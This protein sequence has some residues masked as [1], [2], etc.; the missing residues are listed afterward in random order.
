MV[1]ARVPSRGWRA[2]LG[3]AGAVRGDFLQRGLGQVV[4]D[5]PAV[6]YLLG[7]GQDATDGLGVRAGAVAAH[8]LDTGM[9]PQ[10]GLESVGAAVG[11]D[12]DPPPG[13]DI[14][15]HGGVL[16]PPAQGELVHPE[17]PGYPPGG[18]RQSQQRAQGGVPREGHVQRR[19]QAGARATR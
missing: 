1:V 13:L 10:P 7:V 2:G 8:H 6:P 3:L 4:P 12:V 5:V 17:H 19:E 9:G 18:Q 11:Q 14:D 16:A 15:E